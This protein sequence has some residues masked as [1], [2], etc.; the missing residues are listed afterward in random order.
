MNIPPASAT[1][2][3]MTPLSHSQHCPGSGSGQCSLLVKHS[4]PSPTFRL[5]SCNM[6]IPLANFNLLHDLEQ[7]RQ[8]IQFLN[9]PHNWNCRFPPS[10]TEALFCAY[11]LLRQSFRA[12]LTSPDQAGW[13]H[14]QAFDVHGVSQRPFV[15]LSAANVHLRHMHQAVPTRHHRH[16]YP[17]GHESSHL[18]VPAASPHEMRALGRTHHT[19]FYSQPGNNE[20]PS[21]VGKQHCLDSQ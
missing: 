11:M 7:L 5:S 9:V 1:M 14:L 20:Y 2:L 6:A 12:M 19:I 18:T 3:R 4:L 17:V 8:A 16:K 15:H 13:P 10:C 21:S